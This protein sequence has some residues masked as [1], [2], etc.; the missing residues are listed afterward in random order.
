MVP[1]RLLELGPAILWHVPP[2][3]RTRRAALDRFEGDVVL[4]FVKDARL[5]SDHFLPFC[6]LPV[7]LPKVERGVEYFNRSLDSSNTHGVHRNFPLRDLLSHWFCQDLPAKLDQG[8][9][10]AP[11]RQS[12]VQALDKRSA[13]RRISPL[14]LDVRKKVARAWLPAPVRRA[15]RG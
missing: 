12:F 6:I 15:S 4:Y 3:S 13:L 14:T 11:A 2:V 1:H 10:A 9:L 5:G 7:R 8:S